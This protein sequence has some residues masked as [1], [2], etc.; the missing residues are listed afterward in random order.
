MNWFKNG[1]FIVKGG[2]STTAGRGRAAIEHHH[3]AILRSI[4]GDS[5]RGAVSR[6]V[7]LYLGRGGNNVWSDFRESL[8]PMSRSRDS[9]SR[10]L[11]DRQH[12]STLAS[13]SNFVGQRDSIPFIAIYIYI[14]FFS[15]EQITFHPRSTTPRSSV[16]LPFFSRTIDDPFVVTSFFLSFIFAAIFE[17]RY[18]FQREASKFRLAAKRLSPRRV[19]RVNRFDPFPLMLLLLSIIFVLYCIYR[20]LIS[21]S[22]FPSTQNLS[23]NFAISMKNVI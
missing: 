6:S 3:L 17:A 22:G 7:S 11:D 19:S 14:S 20:F 2:R 4:D 13:Q 9:L 5:A 23:R 12:R 15:P 8:A 16:I 18:T 21:R 1:G 10:A